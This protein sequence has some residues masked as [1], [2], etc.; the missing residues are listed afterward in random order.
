MLG[1]GRY[2]IIFSD[3]LYLIGIA[4]KTCFL[5]K[6][7]RNCIKEKNSTVFCILLRVLIDNCNRAYALNL[8]PDPIR[9]TFEINEG[10]PLNQFKDKDNQTLSDGY[11]IKHLAK[12]D[13]TIKDVYEITCGDIHFSYRGVWRSIDATND[14]IW[15]LQIGKPREEDFPEIFACY[16]HFIRYTKLLIKL[17]TEQGKFSQQRFIDS[18]THMGDDDDTK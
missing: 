13:D 2:G 16:E 1:M 3:R 17:I 9:F 11:L 12:L 6:E 8:V 15:R 5:I 7:V 10:R 14:N 4:D 18:L